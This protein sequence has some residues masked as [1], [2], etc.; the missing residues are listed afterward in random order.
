M[1]SS[2]NNKSMGKQFKSWCNGPTVWPRTQGR[3]FLFSRPHHPKSFCFSPSCLFIHGGKLGITISGISSPSYRLRDS[4][5]KAGNRLASHGSTTLSRNVTHPRTPPADC[6]VPQVTAARPSCK[7]SWAKS[8]FIFQ[9]LFYNRSRQEKWGCCNDYRVRQLMVFGTGKNHLLC[10]IRQLRPR[11]FKKVIFSICWAPS[12]CWTHKL[13][14]DKTKTKSWVS[15][16]L[17]AMHLHWIT[18]QS[19][20]YQK[21]GGGTLGRK[22]SKFSALDRWNY[23]KKKKVRCYLSLLE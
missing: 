12:V 4:K 23:Q 21:K 14:G 5:Q 10:Q 6:L 3:L 2:Y 13:A 15:L 17:R 20:Q 18:T 11:Q 19:V 7:E 1:I 8:Y 9:F 22:V 16:T